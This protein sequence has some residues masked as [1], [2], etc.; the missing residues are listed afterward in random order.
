MCPFR[1]CRKLYGR[2]ILEWRILYL[3]SKRPLYSDAVTHPS[4]G[5]DVPLLVSRVPGRVQTNV[6]S[7]PARGELCPQ[8]CTAYISER[9]MAGRTSSAVVSRTTPPLG[10]ATL[11]MFVSTACISWTWKKADVTVS[12]TI[13]IWE[14]RS[15]PQIPA[16]PRGCSA[17][18]VPGFSVTST[19][20]DMRCTACQEGWLMQNGTCVQ[21][22]GKGHYLPEG[23]PSINGT[24]QCA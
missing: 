9:M 23:S 15:S 5:P 2:S 14:L 3:V 17:C 21:S 24:C 13:P 16:C 6:S 11:R 4:L 18:I 12:L 1:E 19:R 8:D 10:Y 22:C 7:V 20:A